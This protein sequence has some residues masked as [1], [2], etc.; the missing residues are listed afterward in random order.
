[1]GF[2]DRTGPK[3]AT[4]EDAELIRDG[5]VLVIQSLAR[6][7]NAPDVR[8]VEELSER[9][10]RFPPPSGLKK[11]LIR[12]MPSLVEATDLGEPFGDAA[13]AM[14]NTMKLLAF[15][16]PKLERPLERFN[17]QIPTSLG[18]P[19]ARRLRRDA[20]RLAK[21]TKPMRERML[22]TRKQTLE[23]LIQLAGRLGNNSEVAERVDQVLEGLENALMSNDAEALATLQP[24]LLKQVSSAREDTHASRADLQQAIEEVKTLQRTVNAQAEA[25]RNAK[26]KLSQ[27]PLTQVANRRALDQEMPFLVASAQATGEPL[28]MLTLDIDTFKAV[29]DTYGHAAGDVVLRAVAQKAVSLMRSEDLLAR[30]GGD[31]FVA[32]LTQTPVATA[33]IIAERIRTGIEALPF[34]QGAVRFTVTVSIGLSQLKPTEEG[35]VALARA[36]AALYKSKDGGGNRVTAI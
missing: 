16:E 11:E 32:L 28:T 10:E 26:Q 35:T 34:S 25:L 31:E 4:Q 19:Q 1:M 36:D 23:L 3:K 9:L 27:D 29:N 12:L 20:M 22:A 13:R 7:A 21:Q 15:A 5:L 17:E 18:L 8:G 24:Q 30:A 33:S 14:G 2:F 6:R